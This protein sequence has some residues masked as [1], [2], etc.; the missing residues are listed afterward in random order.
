MINKAYTT[1]QDY[2]DNFHIN[3]KNSLKYAQNGCCRNVVEQIL[4]DLQLIKWNM[5]GKTAQN[6]IIQCYSGMATMVTMET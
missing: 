1:N 3:Y 2:F 4:T 6:D 5:V